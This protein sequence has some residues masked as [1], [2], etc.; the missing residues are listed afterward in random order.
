MI[1]L[2]PEA[3][4]AL[5]VDPGF[6]TDP[7]WDHAVQLPTKWG[8]QGGA[9]LAVGA[10]IVVKPA[11]ATPLGSLRLAELFDETDLPHGMF[12]VLPV[13]SKVADGM[14]RDER[15]R[16]ISFTGSSD[17]G[18]Y[19][20]GLD[21]KKRVTLELGGSAGVIVHSDAD[22]DLAA[23]RVAFGGYYQAGQSCISGSGSW[24]SP[25]VRGLG[26][27]VTQIES[28]KVGETWIRPSMSA[29]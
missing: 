17:I 21:P 3:R 4:I 18:W 15:F 1:R 6:P 10:P 14:A 29:R 9:P 26:G 24:F 27:L 28:L 23:Q 11:S 20:K 25:G 16:K 7:S 22:L 12:Q 2:V 8:A 13:S 5:G 19:L